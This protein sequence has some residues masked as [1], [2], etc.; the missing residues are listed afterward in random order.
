MK[1]HSLRSKHLKQLVVISSLAL[2]VAIGIIIYTV[3][4]LN[5]GTY[6]GKNEN[7][8]HIY[9]QAGIE[10]REYSIQGCNNMELFYGSEREN[11][12]VFL[13]CIP[14]L[15]IVNSTD[16][17]M[18]VTSNSD[19]LDILNVITDEENLKVSLKEDIA[20]LS[21]YYVHADKLEVTVY[22]PVVSVS[23]VLKLN[24]EYDVP[25]AQ[26]INMLFSGEVVN[27]KIYNVDAER[28]YGV[29]S[30]SSRA[31]VEGNVSDTVEIGAVHN[32]KIDASM[33]NVNSKKSILS[34]QL[35]GLSYV[36]WADDIDVD[37][38][39]K[40]T[41]LTFLMVAFFALS[42]IA[43]AYFIVRLRKRLKAKA[44]H[45]HKKM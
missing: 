21:G 6:S 13:D 42:A 22:A 34:N 30:G 25:K 33:L 24:V 27:G 45:R 10:T 19:V 1:R 4:E 39:S 40:G 36:E 43:D 28:L 12:V 7:L 41:I 16:Y 3:V 23:T 26:L 11:R 31:T 18:V 35:F 5:S 44:R 8:H 14:T 17:K 15:K 9:A 29:F 2:F 37:I 32:S 20:S 38:L